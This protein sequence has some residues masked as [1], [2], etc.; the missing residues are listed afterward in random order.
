MPTT[1]QE[2]AGEQQASHQTAGDKTE[3]AQ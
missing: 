2:A 1:I 3:T